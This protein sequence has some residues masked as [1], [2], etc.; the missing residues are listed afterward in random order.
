MRKI[1]HRRGRKSGLLEGTLVHIGEKKT[2]KVQIH[3]FCYDEAGLIEK[4]IATPE[5]IWPLKEDSVVW[6]DID[7]LHKTE[8]I[9][10]FGKAFALHPLLLEDIVNTQ[11]RPKMDEYDNCLY[12]VFRMLRYDEKAH[13][14][15]DEQIS[16]VLG[17][18]FILSF[19]EGPG[20][21][22]DPVRDR[23]RHNRGRV[24][25]SGADYLA[26][27]LMDAVVDNYFVVLEKFGDEIERVD[28]ELLRNSQPRTLHVLH[29][30]K[31]ELIFLRRVTWP[32][33]EVL[34]SLTREEYNL[35]SSTLAPYFRDVYDHTVQVIDI[36]ESGRDVLSGMLD[37]YISNVS[38]KMNAI[39]KVLTI[40]STIF[41][42]L[43][44]IVGIYGMNFKHMPELE[45][46]WAYPAVLLAMAALGVGMGFYFRHKKW[47]TSD[48]EV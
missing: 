28:D 44:F 45:I 43:T 36:I 13:V 42:P 20:D 31:Q 15:K 22:F 25:K 40:I 3:G 2:D 46:K 11:Q 17:K 37:V 9:E 1:T 34:G 23:L 38:N 27:A 16:I 21:V 24:R 14:V 6:I 26:Y 32:L 35:V 12:F 19:Q 30:L 7:G 10:S 39:M 18:N 47:L 4:D 41:M 29:H 8:I 33:R 5:D 48:T